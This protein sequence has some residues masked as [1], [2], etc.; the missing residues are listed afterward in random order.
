L[1]LHTSL[2]LHGLHRACR[3]QHHLFV[4]YHQHL[5]IASARSSSY[6]IDSALGPPS[7][8]LSVSFDAA[9]PLHQLSRIAA[10]SLR[11]HLLP[12]IAPSPTTTP[13]RRNH[14]SHSLTLRRPPPLRPA[15]AQSWAPTPSG[16]KSIPACSTLPQLK[17][18]MRAR[19]WNGGGASELPSSW[20]RWRQ[21]PRAGCFVAHCYLQYYATAAHARANLR[22][23][24][25]LL[26][27]CLLTLL[28]TATST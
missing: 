15:L 2:A 26:A 14:T 10:P 27:T 25:S 3:L 4:A 6:G 9:H 17:A 5:A 7:P 24:Q 19:P 22:T 21:S 12:T 16:G 13:R 11:I 20:R 23:H 1:T 8:R 28:T 18:R